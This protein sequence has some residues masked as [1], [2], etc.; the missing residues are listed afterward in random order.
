V[1]GLHF[2]EPGWVH[3][4]W[5]VFAVV[6]LL[7]ALERRGTG[8]LERL[9]SPAL[10]QRLVQRPSPWRRWLRI[11]L[12]GLAGVALV[13]SLMRPQLGLRHV[14]TP[15][16]GAEIMIALDVSRS[17]LAEDVAPNRLERAKAEIADL[18]PYL[19]GDAV[20][21]IAFAG[22]AAVLSPLTPDQGFLRLVLEGAGPNSAQRGGTRLEEPIRMALEGFGPPRG[23]SRALLLITDGEDHDS[24]PR[25]AAAAA[26]ELGVRI[27][28][29]G[30]GD[31]A[32]SEVYVTDPRSGARS[33]LRDADGRPVVSRLDG[34]LLREIALAT[35]GAYV[36]AGTG[37]LDLE[38]IYD[39]HIARLTRGELDPRGRTVRDEAYPW[40]V[41]AGLVLLVSSVAVAGRPAGRAA[42][43]SLAAALAAPAPPAHAQDADGVAEAPA[44]LVASPPATD[45]GPPAAATPGEVAPETPRERY[46]RGVEALQSGELDD[47]ERDLARARRE[48]GDDA[49]LR[50]RATYDLGFLEIRRAGR[51]EGEDPRAALESLHRAADWY[52]D[53]VAQ[54]PDHEDARANLEVALRRAL[55][56]ADRLAREEE[57]GIAERLDGL[58]ERQRALAADA[59]RLHERAAAEPGPLVGDRLRAEFRGTATLQR[60]LLSEAD[61]LAALAGDEYD[62]LEA[63]PEEE[64]SAEDTMRAAQLGGVLHYLHRA[65]ER[66]GQARRQLRLRQSERAYRRASAA[67]SSLKRA[68]DQ[69]RDPIELLDAL[70]G[71]AAPLALQTG[72][73]A[74]AGRE[75][76]GGDTAFEPPPWLTAASLEEEQRAVAERT[77][78]L[79]QRLRAGLE[80]ARQAEA[81][82]DDAL[83]EAVR[84]AEPFVRAGGR[85][86]LA[87]VDAL[88][89]AAPDEALPSQREG[90]AA[91]AE[92]RERFLD[93]RGL[94][95]A[96]YADERRIASV[97]GAADAETRA[98]RDEAIES[99]RTAQARNIERGERLAARLRDEA[100]RADAPAAG[101]VGEA[102][103]P[104]R[105]LQ[106]RQRFEVAA[107]LLDLVLGSMRDAADALGREGAP[108]RTARWSDALDAST[109]ALSGLEDL[110]R[111]FLS[112]VEQLRD[113][114]QRQ[115]DLADATRDA[116][117]LSAAPG[118]DAA[119]EAA[120]LVPRQRDLAE[121][122]LEIANALDRQSQ[123]AGGVVSNDA[124]SGDAAERLRRAAEHVV[125]AEG[126]M[127]EA[128]G[129][130]GST[131]PAFATAREAQDEAL[132]ELGE[133]LALLTPPQDPQGDGESAPEQQ[134]GPD[135]PGAGEEESGSDAASQDP[136]QLLQG[137]RDREAQRQRDR[138]RGRRSGYETVEK[139]W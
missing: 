52:R 38:S 73:L 111:L 70:L 110:R 138:A 100:R 78:E 98:A 53:A 31:E 72:L 51:L 88:A 16:V 108:A 83:L 94:I 87:A 97:L 11:G 61:Q 19:D 112:I 129:R 12:L 103:D 116:L 82:D 18:L 74:A 91:L 60:T 7:A 102:P 32:G 81:P 137:V 23:A 120:P 125:V 13:L 48:A 63:R 131:P 33:L 36:P 15:R 43:L 67:L 22:R 96:A 41:L 39:E 66:M 35:G 26:A 42:I 124:E 71:D 123:E 68:R 134:G 65:R 92:A 84:E 17:M 54:R 27:I 1:N 107:Q 50:F 49:E 85:H 136:A 4:L 128:L 24:F 28:A 75:V 77:G 99:L 86:F 114:A 2:A 79:E 44:P 29:I 133:A 14:A 90:I 113:V 59:A 121:R 47:A 40:F 104:E 130:L 46:N 56:L 106:E 80:G 45:E 30:F 34:E 64:R 117:A 105:A 132:R 95:E 135:E 3:A 62:A 118:R 126:A 115:L 8:A 5:A 9:V 109:D 119:A 139:D 55:L 93:V 101:G 58:V 6:A 10:Q 25:D 37:V 122:G 21:L 127:R 20:G 76:P 89:A 57:G 69:L